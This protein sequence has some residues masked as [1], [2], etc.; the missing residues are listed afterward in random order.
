MRRFSP[1][2]TGSSFDPGLIRRV[3]VCSYEG[4][5]NVVMHAEDGS[6]SVD[7]AGD[8]LILEVRDPGPF[9]LRSLPRGPL[10]GLRRVSANLP[11]RRHSHP[12]A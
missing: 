11:H 4:E 3:A 6:L 1:A 10:H 8:E 2:M 5:M 9:R 7:I 12:T